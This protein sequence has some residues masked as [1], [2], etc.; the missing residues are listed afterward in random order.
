MK[1]AI[2]IAL[3]V[4]VF[5]PSCGSGYH[6]IDN[7]N[8]ESPTDAGK[9]SVSATLLPP[10]SDS[11]SD[12]WHFEINIESY[13]E[14]LVSDDGTQLG[15]LSYEYPVLNLV[16]SDGNSQ[17][18]LQSD[19]PESELQKCL[20]FS[21]LAGAD[22]IQARADEFQKSV[23]TDYQH[24]LESKY[25]GQFLPRSDTCTIE[26]VHQTQYF[27]SVL[28]EWNTFDVKA[29]PRVSLSVAAF[30]L[31]TGSAVDWDEFGSNPDSYRAFVAEEI[32]RLAKEQD[33]TAS[34]FP[35]YED[36]IR[37]FTDATCFYGEDALQVIFGTNSIG[38]YV[39]GLQSFE[40]PYESI[41]AQL[42]PQAIHLLNL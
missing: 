22:R 2:A 17:T 3:S 9:P 28:T 37:S 27:V 34:F 19:V 1:K 11:S 25:D 26:A 36:E 39:L 10:S 40:L 29:N 35:G 21:A 6:A 16:G 24:Y 12:L 20:T 33:R 5:L 23:D 18:V 31:E 30:N 41:I 4:L 42:S 15:Y 32:L 38:A 7:N 13:K 8:P 14:D